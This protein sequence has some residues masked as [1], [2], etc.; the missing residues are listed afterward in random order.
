MTRTTQSRFSAYSTRAITL[1]LLSVTSFSGISCGRQQTVARVDSRT[2]VEIVRGYGQ[3]KQTSGIVSAAALVAS[4][5]ASSSDAEETQG[6][7]KSQIAAYLVERNFIQLEKA[8]KEAR[9]GKGRFAGGVWKLFVIYEALSTPIVGE[10]ANDSDWNVHLT[11]LREWASAQPESVTA[12][13]ALAETYVN[14]AD[15]ARGSGYANTV[16]DDGW[17]LYKERVEI[18]AS[19]LAEASRLKEKCPY[20]Y[21]AMQHVALTQGWEK[22]QARQLFE[23]A[24]AFEPGYYHYYREYGNFLLPKWYGAPGE[25]EAFA[26]EVS[27]RVGGQEGKFLYFEIASLLACQCDSSEAALAEMSWPQIKE[28]YT[29]LEQLYGLSNLKMNRFAYMAF[30]AGDKRAAQAAFAM[31]GNDWDHQIWRSS[32]KYESTRAWAASQ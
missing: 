23:Q 18:A 29:A 14:F 27:I 20:W 9:S 13:V 8:A 31:I 17:K 21:E 7:Y 11:A 32:A 3:N 19:I 15:K 25:T 5:S 12:R 1:I 26:K 22:S 28:G 30:V 4:P 16:S 24:V 2:L 6:E 10:R